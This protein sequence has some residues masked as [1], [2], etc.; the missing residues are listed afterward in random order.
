MIIKNLYIIL[1]FLEFPINF[2]IFI[3][4]KKRKH[5][6]YLKMLKIFKERNTNDMIIIFQ[7]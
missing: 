5:I 2:L 4:F 7:I 3:I 1:I 6:I